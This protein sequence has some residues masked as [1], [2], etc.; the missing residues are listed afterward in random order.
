MGLLSLR[1]E[2]CVQLLSFFNFWTKIY[3]LNG[4]LAWDFRHISVCHSTFV[5]HDCNRCLEMLQTLPLILRDFAVTEPKFKL[6]QQPTLLVCFSIFSYVVFVMNLYLIFLVNVYLITHKSVF[7][8]PITYFGTMLVIA[9]SSA[10]IEKKCS[11]HW[12]FVS[13]K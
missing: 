5:L 6:I 9:N 13:R 8:T 11:F 3:C 7:S 10:G 2:S 4:I 1:I 12:L